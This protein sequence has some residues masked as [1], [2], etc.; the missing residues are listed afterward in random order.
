MTELNAGTQETKDL[1]YCRD[2]IKTISDLV[3]GAAPKDEDDHTQLMAKSA[4]EHDG[5][6]CLSRVGA[7]DE[8]WALYSRLKVEEM[9]GWYKHLS[10]QSQQAS[11]DQMM[12]IQVKP[13]FSSMFPRCKG[14][15]P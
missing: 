7:C 3:P 4:L 15:A 8:A 12:N 6:G 9:K 1:G 13:G 11:I 2:R 5:P 14:K 10:P